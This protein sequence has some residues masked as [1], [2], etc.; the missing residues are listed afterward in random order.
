MI[1][2]RTICTISVAAL[3]TLAVGG[4]NASALPI[5]GVNGVGGT[6]AI[7]GKAA[8]MPAS[9]AWTS[10]VVDTGLAALDPF[11]SSTSLAVDAQGNAAIAFGDDELHL[12]HHDTALGWSIR[13]FSPF[14]ASHEDGY[15]SVV[16]FDAAAR[17]VI[18]VSHR[19][20]PSSAQVRLGD[21]SEAIM[22]TDGGVLTEL[23]MVLDANGQPH[24]AFDRSDTGL[25]YAAWDGT[26]WLVEAVD[27]TI[28]VEV[29]L[30]LDA[31]GRPSIAHSSLDF[32]LEFA[33][34]ADDGTWSI[35]T[36]AT[37]GQSQIHSPSL[38]IDSFGRPQL[39]YI[40]QTSWALKYAMRGPAGWQIETLGCAG[41]AAHA[42]LALDGAGRPHVTFAARTGTAGA[43]RPSPLLA[44]LQH[45]VRADGVWQIDRVDDAGGSDWW[46]SL[47]IGSDGVAR[48]SWYDFASG[49]VRYAE[50]R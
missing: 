39:A 50:R 11:G 25:G 38:A 2:A 45:G 26:S 13:T 48:V 47:V 36:V 12:A 16:R 28:G 20:G 18:A 15:E 31:A 7:G 29:A 14:G 17:P 6:P 22:P 1:L 10:A 30:A 19:A 49:A 42:S 43:A 21:G 32:R 34:R 35:E 24:I 33:R 23:A 9:F 40:D 27:S 5:D 46:S 37:T 4:C 44:P 41:E 8:C 3:A